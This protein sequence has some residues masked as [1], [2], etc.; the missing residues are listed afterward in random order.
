MNRVLKIILLS[1]GCFFTLILALIVSYRTVNKEYYSDHNEEDYLVEEVY[2]SISTAIPEKTIKS[3]AKIVYEYMYES[4]GNV[5]TISEEIPIALVGLNEH[6]IAEIYYGWEIKEF[7]EELVILE[8]K[9]FD[10]EDENYIV[11]VK[12]GFIAVFL[13]NTIKEDNIKEITSTPINALLPDEQIRLQEGIVVKGKDN[14]VKILE[15]Y[16][17]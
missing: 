4:D 13:N 10:D 8:K 12:D 15:D 9:V 1:L 5:Q 14:L 17:S 7:S 2:E 6:Q 11:G 16:G 3:N